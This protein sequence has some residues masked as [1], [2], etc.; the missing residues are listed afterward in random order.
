M[1][2]YDLK[3][4]NFFIN[5]RG[6]NMPILDELTNDDFNRAAIEIDEHGVPANRRSVYYDVVINGRRYPPKYIISVATRLATGIELPAA[7]FYAT[8][9]TDYFEHSGYEVIDR[10]LE[11]ERVVVGEDDESNFPEGNELFVTHRS[12]ERDSQISKKAKEKRFARTGKLECDV[13]GMDFHR[14]YGEHGKGFIEAHH[15]IPVSKLD[16]TTRTRIS[17][18]ALVCSNCHRMLHRGKTLL[19]VEELKNLLNDVRLVRD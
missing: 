15:K 17:D 6:F 18:L 19:T 3:T 10:R 16:G 4:P 2:S 11:A 9:A 7:D 1:I 12:Y 13:C 5:T 14:V 8:E